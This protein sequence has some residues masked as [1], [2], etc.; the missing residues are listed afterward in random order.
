MV[1]K[2]FHAENFLSSL[3]YSL[4]DTLFNIPQLNSL[5]Y[6]EHRSLPS[7]II[8]STCSET[9]KP[10]V[11]RHVQV[12][13][14]TATI[15]HDTILRF[16]TIYKSSPTNSIYHDKTITKHSLLIVCSVVFLII[17][18]AI[19]IKIFNSCQKL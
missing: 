2:T 17:S 14:N 4:H 19:I 11:V 16:D 18:L 15:R 12:K 3:N 10:I 5:A 7:H 13:T 9:I 8:D 6:T 1:D